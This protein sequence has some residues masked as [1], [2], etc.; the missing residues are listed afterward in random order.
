MFQF[1]S[2]M[3]NE[4]SNLNSFI[5]M[6]FIITIMLLIASCTTI[7]SQNADL[8]IS[9]YINSGD[10][11]NLS[12]EY[13]IL[14]DSLEFPFVG[15]LA[16]AMLAHYFNQPEKANVKFRELIENHQTQ[17]G[18]YNALMFCELSLHNY[19]RLG[20][21]SLVSEKAKGLLE[22][23]MQSNAIYDYSRIKHLYELNTK[24]ATFE[25]SKVIFKDSINDIKIPVEYIYNDSAMFNNKPVFNRYYIPLLYN[26]TK[27]NFMFDT[28]ASITYISRRLAEKINVKYVGFDAGNDSYAF[29][30]SLKIGNELI[31][32]NIL[33]IVGN[34]TL[35]HKFASIDAVIG[36]DVIQ[37]FEE[38]HIDNRNK[39][40]IIPQEPINSSVHNKNIFIDNDGLFYLRGQDK[41]GQLKIFLDS[42]AETIFTYSYYSKRAGQ[43]FL[44]DSKGES[45]SHVGANNFNVNTMCKIVPELSFNACDTNIKI[46]NAIVTYLPNKKYNPSYDILWGWDLFS[47]FEKVIINFK[48]MNLA[49]E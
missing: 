44:Q 29:I 43:L 26:D 40:L 13:P 35:V 8:Q 27:Y 41:Y 10:W 42:G 12:K 38:I 34:D 1:T 31:L 16:E 33:A 48:S 4:S 25:S 7:R 20:N 21:Y 36:M 22:Q 2:D 19:Q 5:I 45:I 49:V 3:V 17:I 14:R 28:G 18:A 9:N 46:K 24:L 15:I 47:R 39:L 30:D 37:K 32:K 11:F 6:R 23:L